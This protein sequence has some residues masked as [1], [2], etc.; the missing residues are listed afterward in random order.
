M[1][2]PPLFPMGVY[3]SAYDCISRATFLRKLCEVAAALVVPFTRV[4][5]DSEWWDHDGVMVKAYARERVA[6]KATPLP[7]PFSPVSMRRC[8]GQ[9]RSCGKLNRSW[10]SSMT[11]T[12][13]CPTQPERVP[14][15]T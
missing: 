4:F 11:F 9:T 7:L 1:L 8:A 3:S 6:N 12:S 15:W 10:F 13:S 2:E 14:P 5:Y